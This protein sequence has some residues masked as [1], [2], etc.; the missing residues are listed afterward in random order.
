MCMRGKMKHFLKNI[1]GVHEKELIETIIGISGMKHCTKGQRLYTQG[2][3]VD[4]C[5]FLVSGVVGA[6]IYTKGGKQIADSFSFEPGEMITP[7]TG[8]GKKALTS[9]YAMTEA[10]IFIISNYDMESLY[11]KYPA[12]HDVILSWLMGAYHKQ[13]E[14]K[15]ARYQM[16]AKGRILFF[17]ERYRG[18]EGVLSDRHLASFLDMSPETLSRQKRSLREEKPD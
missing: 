7:L 1:L 12:F 13:W 2:D 18:L 5:S 14:L 8:D 10:D 3:V 15:N 4:T 16:T 17:L 11:K 6:F 9:V